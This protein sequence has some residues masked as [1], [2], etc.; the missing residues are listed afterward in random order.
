VSLHLVNLV[1]D[2]ILA[3]LWL[4]GMGV[5]VWRG[6]RRFVTPN[7][8]NPGTTMTTIDRDT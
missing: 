8:W 2:V 5:L 7:V 1:I 6:T 3:G 4:T